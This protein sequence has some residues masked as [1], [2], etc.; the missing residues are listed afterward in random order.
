MATSSTAAGKPE[1]AAEEMRRREQVEA[2]Q[3]LLVQQSIL[4][5]RMRRQERGLKSGHRWT[6]GRRAARDLG[7]TVAGCI[8]QPLVTE[9][10]APSGGCN[11]RRMEECL[12]EQNIQHCVPEV[13]SLCRI[14]LHWI[15]LLSDLVREVRPSP[16]ARSPIMSKQWGVW[17]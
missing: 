6:D 9:L 17:C 4:P 13:D 16:N 5:G 12:R 3:R 8:H 11:G 14:A 15:D 1:P 2:A 10:S 7:P